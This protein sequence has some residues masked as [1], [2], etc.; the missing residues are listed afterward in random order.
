MADGSIPHQTRQCVV[1]RE[2]QHKSELLRFVAAGGELRWDS[3]QNSGGR[4]AYLHPRLSCIGS[5]GRGALWQR[6]L[7]L[8]E[9]PLQ[10]EAALTQVAEV[11][12]RQD[13]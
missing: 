12:A 8:K 5:A 11:V 6:A 3:Q 2:R 10:L 7:R 13:G 1:C 9:G 4:G